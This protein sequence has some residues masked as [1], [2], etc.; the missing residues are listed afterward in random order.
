MNIIIKLAISIYL[1]SAIYMLIC[2]GNALYHSVHDKGKF[3]VMPFGHFIYIHFCPIVN[4]IRCIKIMKK[5]YEL[6]KR[7]V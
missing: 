7:G 5:E 6:M 4:T 3:F 1:T 2:W